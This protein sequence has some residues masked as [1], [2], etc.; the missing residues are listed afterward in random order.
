MG[1]GELPG[2]D[3]PIEIGNSKFTRRQVREKYHPQTDDAFTE[4]NLKFARDCL[5]AQSC[6]MRFIF[7]DSQMAAIEVAAIIHADCLP[8][9]H[10]LKIEHPSNVIGEYLAAARLYHFGM[11]NMPAYVG[12]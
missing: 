4:A 5:R 7:P 3:V 11:V 9:N 12:A 2:M 10:P 6:V 8:E 1:I